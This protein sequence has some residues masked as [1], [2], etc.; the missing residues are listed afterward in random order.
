MRNP[1][2][3][4]LLAHA[5]AQHYLK[6]RPIL[7]KRPPVTSEKPRLREPAPIQ[8]DLTASPA[9]LQLLQRTESPTTSQTIP[10]FRIQV[11]GTTEKALADS[12][13]FFLIETY[14]ELPVYVTYE[15]PIYRVRVGDFLTK[16]EASQWL[17]TLQTRFRGAFLVPDQIYKP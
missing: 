8:L 1:L 17:E 16:A 14:P 9:L 11:L 4:A 15:V 7:D 12:T 2:I 6:Y 5:L 3:F 13:R 10:G